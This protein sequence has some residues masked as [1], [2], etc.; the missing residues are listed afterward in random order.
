MSANGGRPKGSVLGDR[1]GLVMKQP[2]HAGPRCTMLW[3]PRPAALHRTERSRHLPPGNACR[4]GRWR[5]LLARPAGRVLAGQDSEAV[6]RLGRREGSVLAFDG[7]PDQE[8]GD[9]RVLG[10]QGTVQVAGHDVAVPGTL[11][12]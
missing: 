9:G 10:Q 7:G 6:V 11:L 4:P 8:V 12:A 5:L 3:R 1:R 2:F